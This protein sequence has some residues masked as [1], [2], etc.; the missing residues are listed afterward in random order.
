[1]TMVLIGI[2]VLLFALFV[3][4]LGI[5]LLMLAAAQYW[6]PQNVWTPSLVVGAMIIASIAALA[7]LGLSLLT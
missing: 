1:M 7:G 5:G 3:L 2:S 4:L 6:L